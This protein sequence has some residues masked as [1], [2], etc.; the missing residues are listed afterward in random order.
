MAKKAHEPAA[1]LIRSF[2]RE[3]VAQAHGPTSIS[4]TE[5]ARRIAAVKYA[6]ASIGLEGLH[7][8]DDDGAHARR[9]VDGDITL[10]EFIS[11][12]T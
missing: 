2:M 6:Q 12:P 11:G 4:A 10:A 3:Y 5:R 7:L 1:Q 9:F 8:S